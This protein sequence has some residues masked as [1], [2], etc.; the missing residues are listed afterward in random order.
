METHND[1]KPALIYVNQL[2]SKLPISRNAELTVKTFNSFEKFASEINVRYIQKYK[3]F[4]LIQCQKIN[5]L[6]VREI[7][8]AYGLEAALKYIRAN[9]MFAQR[10]LT[11]ARQM[12]DVMLDFCAESLYEEGFYMLNLAEVSI[13]FDELS[14][15]KNIKIYS[16]LEPVLVLEAFTDFRMKRLQAIKTVEAETKCTSVKEYILLAIKQNPNFAALAQ[17]T[18]GKFNI[19][20]SERLRRFTKETKNRFPKEWKLMNEKEDL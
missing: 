13:F 4:S 12:N 1:N 2:N 10:G 5:L 8:Q 6:K 18:D 9:L 14:K 11:E 19:S 15:G 16:Q 7:G 17:Q 20:Y 3:A